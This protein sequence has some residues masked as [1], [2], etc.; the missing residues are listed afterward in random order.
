MFIVLLWCFRSLKNCVDATKPVFMGIS[1][2][3]SSSNPRCLI[4]RNKGWK[5]SSWC[6]QEWYSLWHFLWHFFRRFGNALFYAVYLFL[7]C[8]E[9]VPRTVSPL[10]H[11]I[12]TKKMQMH[13]FFV[14]VR[15]DVRTHRLWIILGIQRMAILFSALEDVCTLCYYRVSA[16]YFENTVQINYNFQKQGD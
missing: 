3:F 7:I 10:T 1:W 2:I 12:K 16:Y 11:A 15:L 9:T 8:S 5:K 14:L 4:K 13:L 6:G